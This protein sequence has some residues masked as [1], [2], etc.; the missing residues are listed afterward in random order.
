[1]LRVMRGNALGPDGSS[2]YS[3]DKILRVF[4]CY[5]SSS[6]LMFCRRSFRQADMMYVF[7]LPVLLRR[8]DMLRTSLDLGLDVGVR[9]FAHGC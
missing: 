7:I 2:Y 5:D 8:S 3:S 6:E 1:M 9:P 4:W